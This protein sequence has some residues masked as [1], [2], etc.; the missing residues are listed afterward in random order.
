MAVIVKHGKKWQVRIR[1]KNHPP[2]YKTFI[3]KHE[4]SKWAR[5]SER[6]IEK[7]QLKQI[8]GIER[9]NVDLPMLGK[10]CTVHIIRNQDELKKATNKQLNEE[11]NP[12]PTS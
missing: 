12:L 4:A 2:I 6:D 9:K 10:Y 3:S 5:E 11:Y 7:V 8:G 1:K